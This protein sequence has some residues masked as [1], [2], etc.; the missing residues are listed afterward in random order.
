MTATGQDLMAADRY[1]AV[2]VGTSAEG[3]G[4]ARIGLFDAQEPEAR[5]GF[6]SDLES[7]PSAA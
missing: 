1:R 6:T 5:L 2:S 7:R 4:E 3:F